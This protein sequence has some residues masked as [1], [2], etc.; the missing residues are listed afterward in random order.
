MI[1]VSVI[2]TLLL[3]YATSNVLAFVTLSRMNAVP[4]STA[5][6]AAT[7]TSTEKSQDITTGTTIG[8]TRG[9]HLLLED[10]AISRG[11]TPLLN[12][13]KWSIQANERWGIV[14]PNGAGKSTL[15]GAITGTVRMD[16]GKALVAPKVRV[17]YLKQSAV[18]GS[19][20]TV[21]EEAKSEMTV[22]ENARL[23][24][25]AASKMV[26]GG[27]YS[28]EAL[29]ELGEAQEEFERAGGYEQEQ[30]VDSVLKGLGFEPEDSDRLCSDFSGGWQMRIALARLL[31]SAP[32]LLLLDEPSN[33]LDSSARNWLGK[34][35]AGYEGSVVLVSHDVG[36]LDASVN[37][38]AEI[39]GNTL[40]EYR[41][42]SYTKY[43]DEKEFRA[44]SAQ[45]EYERNLEEAARLQSFIDK[46]GA[47]AT[48]AASAQSRVKMLEKMKS[49]GKLD[50]PPVSV[51]STGRKPELT[52]PPPPK[53][54]GE[55]LLELEGAN[56]G[57]DPDLDPL[58]LDINI[59]ISR[60]MKLLLRGPNG[61]GKSTLLKALRGNMP[62]LLMEGER[63]EN[64]KLR[65]GVFTQDL[66]QE[67][68]TT[69][70]AVDLVT[71]Y[72]REGADG[73]INISDEQARGIMGRLNLGGE[74]P[75]RLVGELSGGEKARVALSM[76]ALK[77]SNLLML[78]EPSNH[79]D[80]GCID[81]LATALSGW[82]GKDGAV[83]VISHDRSFCEDVGFTHVGTVMDGKLKLEQRPL[84]DSDWDQYEIGAANSKFQ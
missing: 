55:I 2:V 1:S 62:H 77:A 68:D 26:E 6:F 25:D 13:I 82:G 37:S 31:L 58:L 66:A 4:A 15:L 36:L 73:D 64:E 40:L 12:D 28:E 49:E 65:L 69:A 79:L 8:D 80:V 7:L 39:N 71:A 45:A 3:T 60:G 75:L 51:I 72:A 33:H 61:A 32:S 52:L 27:D 76:F 78:D 23:R 18:S 54:L 11:G 84:R 42:C 50:P 16:T 19:T 38:I 17:G 5:L 21:A 34:Y 46:F 57:H 63:K 56:I 35:I 53:P 14:G 47:S 29:G 9:A 24:L 41:G 43:L 44:K 59:K 70:R 74:K 67:L 20:R 22:V 81:A 48:K 30:R 10:V 83:V